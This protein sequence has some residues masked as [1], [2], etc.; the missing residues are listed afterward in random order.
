MTIVFQDRYILA[1][2]ITL[3]TICFWHGLQTVLN[4]REKN[5]FIALVVIIGLYAIYNLQFILRI[6]FVVNTPRIHAQHTHIHTHTNTDSHL[7]PAVHPEDSLCCNYTTH[8]CATYT[9]SYL[10]PATN[11]GGSSSYL[12]TLK[13]LFTK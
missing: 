2:M 8:T 7:Q 3:V 4:I 12:I 10:Q 6:L 5:D 1:T 11:I 13:S 9:H